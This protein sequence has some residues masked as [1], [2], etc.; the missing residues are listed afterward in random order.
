MLQY[1]HVFQYLPSYEQDPRQ[2]SGLM[3]SSMCRQR[4]SHLTNTCSRSDH[5][6]NIPLFLE[7]C[8]PEQLSCDTLSEELFCALMKINLA[9]TAI[10]KTLEKVTIKNCELVLIIVSNFFSSSSFLHLPRK[11]L[12][13]DGNPTRNLLN[14]G[15]TV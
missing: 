4:P 8:A 10:S 6:F 5:M 1:I 15:E 2:N 14:S 13:S 3:A 11:F 12:S 7:A 9:T